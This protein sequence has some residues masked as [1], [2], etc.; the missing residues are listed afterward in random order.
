MLKGAKNLD[1]Y[2]SIAKNCRKAMSYPL[3][4]ILSHKISC[5]SWSDFDK[6]VIWTVFTVAFFGSFRFGELLPQDKNAFNAKETLLWSDLRFKE[7]FVVLH[8]KV[9][10]NKQ[11]KGEYIDLFLQPD[12]D[13]CPFKALSRLSKMQ[14]KS[15]AKNYPVFTL[16]NGKFLTRDTING[17]LQKLL[18]PV[19]KEKAAHITG[20]SFRAAVPSILASRPDLATQNDLQMWGR[21]NTESF[22]LYTR[23][24]VNQK[25]IIYNKIVC[26]LNKLY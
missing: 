21:W 2:S 19:L 3:L 17:I 14:K 13:Y 26:A 18:Y 4:K 24:K 9:T 11:A 5:E 25:R 10:K 8:L 1:L 15:L 7:D 16:E 20:H 6:Q 22:L 23:L 12:C